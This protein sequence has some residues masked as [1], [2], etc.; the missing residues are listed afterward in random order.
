MRFAAQHD[1]GLVHIHVEDDGRGIAPEDAE[2]VFEAG[3]S[4][5]GGTGL[6]LHAVR[7]TVE[8][9]GGQVRCVALERGT[10]FTITLPRAEAPRA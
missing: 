8:E 2:R 9:L 5:S 10:R 7:T 4:A 1:D 3:W 6:G